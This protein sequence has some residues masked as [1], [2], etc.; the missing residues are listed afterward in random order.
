MNADENTKPDENDEDDKG[1]KPD[2]PV[3]PPPLEQ[4][5]PPVETK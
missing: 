3:W 1:A 2:R 4:K 5:V